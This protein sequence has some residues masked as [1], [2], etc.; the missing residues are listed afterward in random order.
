VE[1]RGLTSRLS[2]SDM[3]KPPYWMRWEGR[4]G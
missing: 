4:L 1:H 3:P 2:S